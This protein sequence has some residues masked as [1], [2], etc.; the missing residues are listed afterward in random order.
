M[1]GIIKKDLALKF[2]LAGKAIVTFL[3]T[4]TN[5]RF[6]YKISKHKK[7][8]IYY[9]SVLTSPDIYTYIGIINIDNKF[10]HS[11]KSHI[12]CNSQSVKVFSWIFNKLNLNKDLIPNCIEFYHSGKCG[13]CGKRLTVPFSIETGFGPEC[14]KKVMNKSIER[15][16]KLNLL[17][18]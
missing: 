2:I 6:T 12:N 8:P 5:N 18:K 1:N 16:I 13:K 15:N 11:P 7:S 17:F 10:I 9:V 3:N 4:D 14:I